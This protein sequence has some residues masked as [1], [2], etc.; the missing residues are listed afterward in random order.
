MLYYDRSAAFVRV[1]KSKNNFLEFIMPIIR[2][3]VQNY[4]IWC[5]DLYSTL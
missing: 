1:Y 3:F 2:L 4:R 5:I